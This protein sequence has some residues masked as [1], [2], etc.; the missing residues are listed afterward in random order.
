MVL[1]TILGALA[2]ILHSLI[3]IYTWVIIIASILSFIRPDPNNPL[4]QILYRL[5]EPLFAKM[6]SLLP[7]LVFNGL[8]LSA[9]AVIILLQFIDMTFVKLLFVYAQG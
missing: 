5:T 7:F 2:T 6:R 3:T 1:N 4:V 9:L 8:D